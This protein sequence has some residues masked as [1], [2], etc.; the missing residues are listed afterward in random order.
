MIAPTHSDYGNWDC[1]FIPWQGFTSDHVLN[2]A[3]IAFDKSVYKIPDSAAL[4]KFLFYYF[5]PAQVR[6]GK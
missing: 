2:I 3:F 6:R 4:I 5:F 1:R